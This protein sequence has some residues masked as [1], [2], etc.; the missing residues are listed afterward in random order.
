MGG[1]TSICRDEP[2]PNIRITH[3]NPLSCNYSFENVI[4]KIGPTPT[5]K[6]ELFKYEQ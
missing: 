5:T 3:G 2:I 6:K 4:K 1:E